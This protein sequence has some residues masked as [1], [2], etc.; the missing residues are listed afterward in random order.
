MKPMKQLINLLKT[1]SILVVLW[2]FVFYFMKNQFFPYPVKE[3][4][5]SET[6]KEASFLYLDES[7]ILELKDKKEYEMIQDVQ[8]EDLWKEK[9]FDELDKRD[10]RF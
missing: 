3:A 8:E 5:L 10:Y 9:L 7:V 4:R 1:V 6:R 2:F